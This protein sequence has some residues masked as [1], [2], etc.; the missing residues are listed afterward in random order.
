MLQER[1]GRLRDRVRVR[2]GGLSARLALGR[3]DVARPCA[4]TRLFAGLGLPDGVLGSALAAFSG[5]TFILISPSAVITATLT[6]IPLVPSDCKQ[7][8]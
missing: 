1:L 4:D 3:R 8:L 7:I 5:T 6:S 2:R